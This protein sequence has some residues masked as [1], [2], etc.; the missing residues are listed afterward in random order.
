MIPPPT[1]TPQ[2]FETIPHTPAQAT[3]GASGWQ[4]LVT[5][6]HWFGPPKPQYVPDG[7]SPSSAVQ[8]RVPPQPLPIMP[9]L[10]PPASASVQLRISAGHSSTAPESGRSHWKACCTPHTSPAPQL[11][12][13]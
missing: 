1:S 9:Q 5:T 7:H 4:V 8:S 11:P 12:Q 10:A 6:P 3:S 2:P 13:S